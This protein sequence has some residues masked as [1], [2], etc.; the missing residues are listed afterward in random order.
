VT[1]DGFPGAAFAR[2]R[3]SR[4]SHLTSR[5]VALSEAELFGFDRSQIPD[6]DPADAE[7]AR[8]DHPDLYRNHL[9]IALMLDG[10]IARLQPADDQ[11]FRGM[12]VAHAEIAAW[13]RKGEL[14]P[15][16]QMHDDFV[17]D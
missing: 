8:R 10:R 14:L 13:L 9:T 2:A 6:W 1:L 3:Q 11:Y 12:V 16:G 15:G 7:R 17:G 4:D 5:D